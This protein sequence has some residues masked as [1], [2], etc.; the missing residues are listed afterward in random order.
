[1]KKKNMS[2]F[3]LML[4]I[5]TV[6]AELAAECPCKDKNQ[7]EIPDDRV[8]KPAGLMEKLESLKDISAEKELLLIDFTPSMYDREHIEYAGPF[9]DKDFKINKKKLR[10]YR[11]VVVYSHYY[12]LNSVSGAVKLL[13]KL[14]IKNYYVLDSFTE[15]RNKGFPVVRKFV[16]IYVPEITAAA[17]P[18]DYDMEVYLVYDIREQDEFESGHI[19]EAVNVPMGRFMDREFYSILPAD[20]KIVAYCDDGS[21]SGV[22]VR[23]LRKNGVANMYKLSGG[24]YAWYRY[25]KEKRGK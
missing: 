4:L 3:L 16:S 11:N 22:A 10:A 7:F 19:P 17:L 1:M 8:L 15:W 6:P 25:H 21:R 20:G 14:G 5:Y 23:E 9:E 13:N 24:Y 18:A 2:C 12:G